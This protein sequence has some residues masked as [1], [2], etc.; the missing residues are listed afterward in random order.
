[1]VS[2]LGFISKQN[3]CKKKLLSFSFS[4]FSSNFFLFII[5]LRLMYILIEYVCFP[6]KK[7][8]KL[9]SSKL[10]FKRYQ[11]KKYPNFVHFYVSFFYPKIFLFL[12]FFLWFFSLVHCTFQGGYLDGLRSHLGGLTQRVKSWYWGRPLVS[13]I[14]FFI[15]I[16]QK[17][18]N[19]IFSIQNSIKTTA[20][21]TKLLLLKY[22][23]TIQNQ[24]TARLLKKKIN[25]NFN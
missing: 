12:F 6:W 9:T 18:T 21:K 23:L 1:M 25:F 19:K 11:K 13:A 4:F 5:L 14:V 20:K 7:K 2:L 22:P 16:L 24:K 15:K 3:F 17:T 10:T 8:T